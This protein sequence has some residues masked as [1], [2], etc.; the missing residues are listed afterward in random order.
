MS[1]CRKRKYALLGLIMK[2]CWCITCSCDMSYFESNIWWPATCTYSHSGVDT[3][4]AHQN[5]Y[6]HHLMKVGHWQ[7][8]D[9][10]LLLHRSLPAMFVNVITCSCLYFS[11]MLWVWGITL[12]EWCAV[13]ITCITDHYPCKLWQSSKFTEI[14]LLVLK[15]GL[16]TCLFTSFCRFVGFCVRNNIRR[17]LSIFFWYRGG[18][19][20]EITM[21]QTKEGTKKHKKYKVYVVALGWHAYFP[22]QYHQ[23]PSIQNWF[24][25]KWI[26]QEALFSVSCSSLWNI[27]GP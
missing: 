11:V 18:W 26:G 5:E 14:Q 6:T 15:C 10:T 2:Y 24:S 27:T 7:H 23:N 25:I 4:A 12:A 21:W 16:N 20:K 17:V 9:S 8:T 19:K 22:F 1:Y 13:S 3:A